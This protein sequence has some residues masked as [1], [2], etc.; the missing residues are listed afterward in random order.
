M[1]ASDSMMTPQLETLLDKVDSKFSLVT[2]AARRARDLQQYYSRDGMVSNK[3]IPPQVPSL[4]KPLSMGFEEIA[5]DKIVR[6]SGE[7]MAERRAAEEA[8]R[9]DELAMK[10]AEAEEA[11]ERAEREFEASTGETDA[12]I[13]RG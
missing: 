5:V 2:L 12:P 4:R 7:E 6:V 13:P 10:E 1:A 11:R 8:A 9:A 3:V